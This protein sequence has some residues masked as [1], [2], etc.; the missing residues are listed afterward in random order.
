MA[1]KICSY[2]RK[3]VDMEAMICPHCQSNV[4][5]HH[6]LKLPT[7]SIIVKKK[8][9]WVAGLI[10]AIPTLLAALFGYGL[11]GLIWGMIAGAVV[12]G[13]IYF[14][15]EN[16]FSLADKLKY[17]CPGC[18]LELTSDVQKNQSNQPLRFSD[19]RCSRCGKVTRIELYVEQ[20]EQ[21]S[22]QTA[23]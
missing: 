8:G 4:A 23:G 3:P 7:S 18:Q 2:C 5:F 13:V 6:A 19:I 21:V 14:I 16:I 12:G 9:K 20:H 17:T 15:L 10:T 11:G 22:P 1:E